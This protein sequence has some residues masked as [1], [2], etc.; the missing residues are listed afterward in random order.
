MDVWT[1]EG[2]AQS[3]PSRTLHA[4]GAVGDQLYRA[5]AR[6]TNLPLPGQRPV[7]LVLIPTAPDFLP[8]DKIRRRYAKATGRS[9][10][11]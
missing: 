2:A 9:S 6:V 7:R 10:S 11:R 3:Q 8:T 5:S 4:F 1:V